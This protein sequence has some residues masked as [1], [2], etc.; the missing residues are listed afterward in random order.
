MT[1]SAKATLTCHMSITEDSDA[2]GERKSSTYG[3]V[4]NYLLE[5]YVAKDVTAEAEAGIMNIMQPGNMYGV[6]N[7]KKHSGKDAKI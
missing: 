1:E 5:T 6:R 7:C 2:H 3:E 4:G